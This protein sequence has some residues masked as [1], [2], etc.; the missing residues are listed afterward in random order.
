MTNLDDMLKQA[1][2]TGDFSAII[3]AFKK[4]NKELA[5]KQEKEL[6]DYS[7]RIKEANDECERAARQLF[8]HKVPNFLD[9]C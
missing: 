3:Q 9:F 4:Q 1:R 2:E 8:N 7:A 6:A 5:E